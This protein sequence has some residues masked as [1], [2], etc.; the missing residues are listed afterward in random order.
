MISIRIQT[1]KSEMIIAYSKNSQKQF[2]E[3]QENNLHSTAY[4]SAAYKHVRS[5]R[6]T[7]MIIQNRSSY[8]NPNEHVAR[9]FATV[10]CFRFFPFG[11]LNSNKHSRRNLI[12]PSQYYTSRHTKFRDTRRII[13]SCYKLYCLTQSFGDALFTNDCTSSPSFNFVHT[14]NSEEFF[15]YI[16]NTFVSSW[17]EIPIRLFTNS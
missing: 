13:K 14:Q 10:R 5:T 16:L 8:V 2:V 12:A 6:G 1:M 15:F 3:L 4:H 11:W 9:L 17:N 7:V